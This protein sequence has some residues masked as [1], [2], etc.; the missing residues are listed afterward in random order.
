[1][2]LG[3][4]AAHV[5]AGPPLAAAWDPVGC[6]AA[7]R[8]AGVRVALGGSGWPQRIQADWLWPRRHVA[9]RAP[10]NPVHASAILG[11]RSNVYKEDGGAEGPRRR[12]VPRRLGVWTT[13]GDYLDSL[14]LLGSEGARTGVGGHRGESGAGA[15]AAWVLAPTSSAGRAKRGAT[16]YARRRARKA[17]TG[18]CRAD[19]DGTSQRGHGGA[20]LDAKGGGEHGARCRFTHTREGLR[21]VAGRVR[22]DQGRGVLLHSLPAMRLKVPGHGEATTARFGQSRRRRPMRGEGPRLNLADP[23]S[24]RARAL[25]RGNAGVGLAACELKHERERVWLGATLRARRQATYGGHDDTRQ[26]G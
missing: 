10:P 22:G 7:R 2:R 15:G 1:V 21:R 6:R 9:T 25:V 5:A 3:P 17:A 12:R 18:R 11:A 8:G 24:I 19:R 23:G 20:R 13:R 26:L 4:P 14:G 16:A